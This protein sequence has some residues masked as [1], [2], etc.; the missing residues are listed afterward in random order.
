MS[1]RLPAGFSET[2]RVRMLQFTEV[3]PH[4]T[5]DASDLQLDGQRVSVV[6]GASFDLDPRDRCWVDKFGRVNAVRR[7]DR[8]Y[9]VC[10]T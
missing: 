1:Y 2:S 5:R 6:D 9:V 7:G 10:E 3:A 4:E 8:W